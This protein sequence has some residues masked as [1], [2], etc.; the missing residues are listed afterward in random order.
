MDILNTFLEITVYSGIIF[1]VTMLL[2]KLCKNSM[3]PWLHYTVWFVL[4]IRL[5]LPFT[6]ESTFHVFSLPAQTQIET[7]SVTSPEALAPAAETSAADTASDAQA[8][9]VNPVEPSDKTV[10][11]A[12]ASVP[13]KAASLSTQD[14]LLIVWLSGVGVCLMYLT[15]LYTTLRRRV[16]R[17][18]APPSQRLMALFEQTKAELDIRANI[19]LICQYEYG[20]PALMLPRTILMPVDTLVAMND[21]QVKFALRHE[22]MHYKHRDHLMCLLLS[23]LNAVHWFNP[24]VWLAFRQMRSDME[25]ACDG[26]VVKRLTAAQKSRYASLIVS[27]FSQ[28]QRRQLVLGMAQGDVKKVAEKRVRGIFMNNKSQKQVKLISIIVVAMLITTCFTTACQPTPADKIIVGKN[29]NLSSIISNIAA[30]ADDTQSEELYSKLG[31]PDHWKYSAEEY[32]GKLKINADANIVLPSVTQLPVASAERR[33]FTQDDINK[34]AAV[35]FGS[36]VSW[37]ECLM[38][39]KEDIERMLVSDRQY[40]SELDGSNEDDAFWIEKTQNSIKSLEEEYQNAP[41]ESDAKPT[42]IE[43]GMISPYEDVTY[44]GVLANTRIGDEKY[45]LSAGDM[46][47]D[48]VYN[49]HVSIGSRGVYFSGTEADTPYGVSMTSEQAAQQAQAI[50]SQLTED[51]QLCFVAPT[52]TSKDEA[53]RNWGWACVFMRSIN[54]CPTTYASEEVGSSMESMEQNP[55]RYEKM[56]IV[57]DDKGVISF[58]WET[59]MNVTTIDNDNADLLSFDEISERAIDQI[60]RKF[61]EY[62]VVAEGDGGTVNVSRVELGLMRVAKQGSPDYYYLPVWNFFNTFDGNYKEK[63]GAGEALP[64]VDENGNPTSRYDGY[65]QALGAV[66][67]NALDG[68]VIDRNLGY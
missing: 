68:S 53:K 20:S 60:S 5:M 62:G 48:A 42:S 2:K 65:P 1:V 32:S 4:V 10:S 26:A 11:P 47:S 51:L 50:A 37:F 59:P 17:N 63:P 39:T 40:L 14:F 18:A 64:P 9:M 24:F 6:L 21:E 52:A 23:V 29:D 46:N 55:V 33:E 43:I 56:V 45:L 15:T 22:L 66:T 16:R 67:I 38:F 3:S 13:A 54:G 27:L 28:P 25:V 19:K 34:V 31:A 44:K 61:G 36:D 57:L 30:P 7:A 58:T 8:K 49:I 12:S 41:S 35:L